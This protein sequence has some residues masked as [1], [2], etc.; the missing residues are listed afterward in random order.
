MFLGFVSKGLSM[1]ARI[2]TTRI[3]GLEAMS[4][5]TLASPAMV[6]L[7]TLAQMGLPTAIATLISKHKE[8]S[9]KIFLCGLFLSFIISMV[10][11]LITIWL[12]PYLAKNVLKNEAVTLTLYALA[13]LIPL[14]GL[15]SL[16]KG[17]FIGHNRV[18]MTAKSSI[19]EEISRI[20]FVLLFL[21]HF[22]KISPEY[23][24]FGAMLG[25]CVGEVFQSLYLLTESQ[26]HLYKRS[27]EV[28][29]IKDIHPLEEIPGILSLS[30]PITL[31][32]IVGSLT[33]FAEPI[34][35]TNV[36]LKAGYSA[37]QIMLDYGVLNGYAMPILLL[38][39]FFALALAN[40]LL[41]NMSSLVGKKE[42]TKA[43]KLFLNVIMISLA[44]GI[45]M[46]VIFFF[47]GKTILR[48][49]YHTEEGA[50]YIHYLAFPF[51][52]YY[53]ES[54]L[55]N[56]MHALGL[57]KK[58]FT[59]TVLSCILRILSL[60]FLLQRYHIMAV[61]LSTILEIFLTIVL[62]SYHVLKTFSRYQKE[63]AIVSN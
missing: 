30:L 3:I 4:I 46:S 56:A 40:Y 5:Y 24:A 7:I 14:V 32:R 2:L 61:A 48:I 22:T 53:I 54:P 52:L 50:K 44:I 58:A 45:S 60:L 59:T 15:S 21:D 43:K 26:F 63:S 36:L 41:P 49:L 27:L 20:I 33:Y 38:P 62:N 57:T 16:L 1:I 34:L 8:R 17:Y 29:Q 6:F 51:I 11:M 42:F 35:T 25:V 39:G 9:K 18:K 13:L 23:G 10:F 55:N 19:A 37:N 28:F 31:S 47:F 12:S